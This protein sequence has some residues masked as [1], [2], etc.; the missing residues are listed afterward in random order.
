LLPMCSYCKRVRNDNNYWS[1]IEQYLSENS[2]LEL[3]HGVCGDCYEKQAVEMGFSVEQAAASAAR[4]RARMGP[5]IT[6][7]TASQEV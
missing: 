2:D 6:E 1:Q 4:H 3:S 7:S 5:A